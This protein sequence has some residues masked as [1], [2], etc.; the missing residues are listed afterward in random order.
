MLI[1]LLGFLGVIARLSWAAAATA[2]VPALTHVIV[3]MEEN[4]G[5][6]EIIG[7]PQAPYIN[8][9]LRAAAL[10]TKSYAVSH[11]SLPNYLALYCGSTLGVTDDSCP[12]SFKE[13]NL[14]SELLDAKLT[15]AGYSEDLPATGA[16]V[17]FAGYYARKH[18]PWAYFPAD[19]P[20]NNRP[21][22]DFP[23]NLS[24]LP[25]VSWVIPNQINDMHSGPIQQADRW[26]QRNLSRY[27]AWAQRNNSLLIVDWD[28]DSGGFNNHIPTI[29][30][31]PMVK[32]GRYSERINHYNVLRTIEDMYGLSHLGQ[33]AAAAPIVDVWR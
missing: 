12:L 16:E 8:R 14:Q 26:L 6:E 7:S 15:F 1:L 30:V 25:T 19:R 31:G 27:V 20:A 5:Y 22:T 21:F 4:H 18:V 2:S 11:P 17:C 29:F 23:N 32:P 3:V 13:R 33:S 10:F 9:I 24:E 28:E